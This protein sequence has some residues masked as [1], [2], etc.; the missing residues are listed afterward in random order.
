M[1][2]RA[3]D[4]S[5]WVVGDLKWNWGLVASYNGKPTVKLITT[6]NGLTAKSL[7]SNTKLDFSEVEKEK[8]SGDY[9]FVLLKDLLVHFLIKSLLCQFIGMF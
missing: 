1:I 6:A 9:F 4:F 5:S 8:S 3:D 2:L 7:L